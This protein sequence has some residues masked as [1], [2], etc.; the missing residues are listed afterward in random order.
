MFKCETEQHLIYIYFFPFFYAACFRFMKWKDYILPY[1]IYQILYVRKAES[2][3]QTAAFERNKA[4]ICFR[5]ATF[6]GF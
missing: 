5:N 6:E 1:V 4:I 2:E 3:L